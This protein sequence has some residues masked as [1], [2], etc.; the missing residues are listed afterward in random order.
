MKLLTGG[1]KYNFKKKS[2]KL[3]ISSHRLTTSLTTVTSIEPKQSSAW[4]PFFEIHQFWGFDEC[5]SSAPGIFY[6][7][8]SLG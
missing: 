3:K 6:L 1:Q 8:S 4:P 2:L 5:A 7:P